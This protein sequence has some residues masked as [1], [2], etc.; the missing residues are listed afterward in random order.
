MYEI[1]SL[2]TLVRTSKVAQRFSGSS[3]FLAHSEG[4]CSDEVNR[5]HSKLHLL[6]TY[7][8]VS[9]VVQKRKQKKLWSSWMLEGSDEID[10]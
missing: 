2:R 8:V 10:E 6:V 9:M 7:Q 5:M 1:K 4:S 3:D